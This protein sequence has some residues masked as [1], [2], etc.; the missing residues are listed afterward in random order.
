MNKLVLVFSLLLF[1]NL[2]SSHVLAFEKE[3]LNN[4]GEVNACNIGEV[5]LLNDFPSAR[6]DVCEQVSDTVFNIVLKPENKPINSSPWYAFKVVATQPTE[7]KINMKVDGKKHRYLPKVSTDLKVWSLLEYQDDEDVRSLT[8]SAGPKP[9]YIAAQEIIDNQV[10]VDWATQLKSS[11]DIHYQV[12]GQSVQGRPIYKIESIKS[13][14]NKWLVL[15]GR[16]HP[17][18]ITGALAL[19]PF[20]ETVLADTKLAKQFRSQFNILIVP[21]INPDGV[22]I[23][24]WRHNANGVDL[25]RDWKTFAQP[26]VSAIHEYLQQIVKSGATLN[27]AVDFHSTRYDVF[28]TM[29]SDYG[30][31]QPYLVNNW[32]NSLDAKYA[33]FS[34]I[35]K[36]GNNPGKGV[37]KQYFADFYQAHAITYEMG[38]NT[39]R[40]FIKKLASDAANTLMETMLQDNKELNGE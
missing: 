8:I 34:V 40:T 20:V 36:T 10:Y 9:T 39:D 17:P 11:K 28:Y 4:H 31:K 35:Q 23:G 32:L 12:L 6:L 29:P 22:E 38:D 13:D 27:M 19:F 25:N 7:I 24:N 14:N 30:V 26:E 37:F 2:L 16:M 5:R 33:D 18:E 15:L 21:N 1:S 3:A